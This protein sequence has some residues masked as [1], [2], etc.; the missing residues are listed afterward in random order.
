MPCRVD[1]KS[2]GDGFAGDGGV[3]DAFSLKGEGSSEA[4]GF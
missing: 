2:L 4:T 3:G 1:Q